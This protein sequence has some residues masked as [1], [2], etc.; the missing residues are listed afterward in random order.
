MRLWYCFNQE[1]GPI[2]KNTDVSQVKSDPY[3]LPEG[4]LWKDVNI[5]N[6]KQLKMLYAFLR[7]N[8][9]EDDENMFR[10]D[11]STRFLYWHLSSPGHKK[12]WHLSVVKK[13]EDGSET[14]IGFISAIPVKIQV[15]NDFVNNVEINFLCVNSKY[16]KFRLATVLIKE[17]T[18]RTNLQGIWQ[19]V[20]TA[21][22]LLTKPISKAVYYH[23][24]INLKKLL[25]IKFTYLP[26]KLNLAKA[27]I[28]YNLPKETTLE[29]LRPMTK[30]DVDQVYEILEKYLSKFQVRMHYSREEVEHWF[31]PRSEVIY[32][33]VVETDGVVTDML[34]FYLL[35]SSILQHEE[36]KK[37][38]A[39]YS[40]F[41]VP[42]KYTLKQLIKTALTL[43]KQL[44]F[45]VYNCL[46]VMEN[47]TVFEDLLF[48]QGDGSLKY[49]LYNYSYPTI[50]SKDIGIVLM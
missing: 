17:I 31:L 44:K 45:D 41:N 12:L 36:H 50:E 13:E 5:E 3:K 42:G 35:P 47:G 19:A 8:Y 21:G 2:N 40:F 43:C 23:R 37:L 28:L 30:D 24:N 48:G 26:S 9:V 11:Y 34:S 18:R 20:Y 14:M 1:I 39:A 33:Y 16:R 4:F 29:G 38:N 25:D 27:K 32:T 6:K 22:V 15:S 7:D 49:Y 46:N 10:F